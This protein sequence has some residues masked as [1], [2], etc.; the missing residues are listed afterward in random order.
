MMWKN[1]GKRAETP[2]M[3]IEFDHNLQSSLGHENHYL[4]LRAVI[5]LLIISLLFCFSVHES[6]SLSFSLWRRQN[7]AALAQRCPAHQVETDAWERHVQ[8][9]TPLSRPLNKL[10]VTWPLQV[11]SVLCTGSGLSYCLRFPGY[12]NCLPADLPASSPSSL[13]HFIPHNWTPNLSMTFTW[14]ETSNGFP[15][16][17]RLKHAHR[18]TIKSLRVR[19]LSEAL[20]LLLYPG[21]L[22]GFQT[23]SASCPKGVTCVAATCQL[24]SPGYISSRCQLKYNFLLDSSLHRLPAQIRILFISFHSLSPSDLRALALLIHLSSPIIKSF[25]REAIKS[26]LQICNYKI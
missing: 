3:V 17:L 6:K 10:H 23:H 2:V 7:W 11:R 8:Y 12:C 26:F 24:P 1:G 25:M 9:F 21:P 15:L 5:F 22:P 18:Q 14:L 16:C 20:P 4:A 19:S 13:F